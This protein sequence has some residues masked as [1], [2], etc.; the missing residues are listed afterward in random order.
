MVCEA[1]RAL[2]RLSY[3]GPVEIVVVIDGSTDGTAA[4][5]ARLDC[6]FRLKVL[7]QENRGQAAARNRGAIGARGDILLFLDDDMICDPQL[8][9]QHASSHQAGA[10]AVTGEVT[11]HPD[12][13]PGFLK[14]RLA[15][16]ASWS[17]GSRPSAFNLYS[18]NLSIRRDVFR[19]VGGFDEEFTAGGYGGEDLDLGLRLIERYDLRHNEAAIAWQKNLVGPLEHMKRAGRVAASDLRLIAKHP[20]V[21]NE[22]LTHRGAPSRLSRVPLLP[23]VASVTAAAFAEASRRTPFRSSSLLARLYFTARSLAYWSAFN[24]L[25]GKDA[26]RNRQHV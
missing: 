13:E 23:A 4:A 22:L 20:E 9:Q 15:A 26:L 12:S 5:L 10:D 14:D 7:E 17:R 18:G 3:D 16:A 25:G 11:I 8:L 19:E 24:R 6:P 21:T 1:V 2:S